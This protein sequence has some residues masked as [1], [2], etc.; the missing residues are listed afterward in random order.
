LQTVQHH[1]HRGITQLL[2]RLPQRRTTCCNPGSESSN[3]SSDHCRD[4]FARID[5]NIGQS[6]RLFLRYAHNRRN[7]I[8]N[9]ANGYTGLGKST[10][11][12]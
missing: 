7:Q 6:N 2:A 10:A 4:S 9:G 11:M 8:D 3:T 12:N 5:H 1:R